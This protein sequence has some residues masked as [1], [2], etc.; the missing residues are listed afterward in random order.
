MKILKAGINKVRKESGIVYLTLYFQ[1]DESQIDEK[2]KEQFKVESIQIGY[3]AKRVKNNRQSVEEDIKKI[4]R[5]KIAEME[6]MKEDIPDTV[7]DELKV[8]YDRKTD[9]LK[10]EVAK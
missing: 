1:T 3:P 4:F 6:E 2:G 8:V 9:S 5:E 10:K 7:L